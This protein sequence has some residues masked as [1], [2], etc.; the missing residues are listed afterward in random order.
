MIRLIILSLSLIFS[1]S[2]WSFKCFYTLAKD[3]CWKD[4]NVSVEVT[5]SNTLK[6]LFTVD[7]P[8]GTMWV[9]KEFTCTASQGFLYVA[10]FTPSFW[11]SE[12]DKPYP[13]LRNWT[14]PS[15]INPG[16][17]AWT[18]SVC[19]PGDFSQVPLPPKARGNCQCDFKSIPEPKVK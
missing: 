6:K 7:I 17:L 8:A 1:S 13:A 3:S 12:K 4:Y 10:K 11:E 2:I 5:D 9:R 15:Q 18:L 19:F 14:L 16:D